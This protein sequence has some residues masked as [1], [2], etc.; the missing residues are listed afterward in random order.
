MPDMQKLKLFFI[1]LF[2][3]VPWNLYSQHPTAV[4]KKTYQEKVARYLQKED[5][6]SQHF[7]ILDSGI[8]LYK[9][10]DDKNL[11]NPEFIV[12]W[13]ELEFYKNLL[14]NSNQDLLLEFY[15]NQN[16]YKLPLGLLADVFKKATFKK[17]FNDGSL[18]G[19]RIA[20][21]PGHIAGNMNMAKIEKK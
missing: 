16:K 5:S 17:P 13:S 9:N 11:G 20:I 14:K 10:L 4:L 19:K 6:V 15:T 12:K 3:F 7:A 18:K 8:F 1:T 2:C 21:D